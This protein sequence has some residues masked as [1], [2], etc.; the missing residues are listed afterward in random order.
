MSSDRV[1]VASAVFVAVGLLGGGAFFLLFASHGEETR[2]VTATAAP[3]PSAVVPPPPPVAVVASTPPPPPRHY[4]PATTIDP[5]QFD[6]ELF[7]PQALADAQKQWKDAT[8]VWLSAVQV[9]DKGV[10]DLTDGYQRTVSYAFRSASAVD[11]GVCMHWVYVDEKGA[12]SETSDQLGPKLCALPQALL[13]T[14]RCTIKQ[15]LAHVAA[16]NPP[17]PGRA[18][19]LRWSFDR[20]NKGMRADWSVSGFPTTSDGKATDLSWGFPGDECTK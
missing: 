2:A 12:W 4:W 14:P 6:A 8:L 18:H 20:T 1:L 13:K 11:T 10:S 19:V 7:L 9:D 3:P 15:A 16:K 5:K 17:R